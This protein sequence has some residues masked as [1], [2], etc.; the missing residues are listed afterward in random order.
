[1]SNRAVGLT[2]DQILR[3]LQAAG[4][5]AGK[6]LL[7]HS[8]MRTFGH[9]EGGAETVVAALLEVL[10]ERATSRRWIRPCLPS[11]SGLPLVSCLP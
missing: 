1:M 4:L 10:G 8:A 2:R 11:M 5:R 9:I 6:V 3:G 7:V